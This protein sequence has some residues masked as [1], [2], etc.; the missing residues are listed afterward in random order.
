MDSKFGNVCCAGI[1]TEPEFEY[2]KGAGRVTFCNQSSY[3][4]AVKARFVQ[5]T[6]A[7]MDKKVKQP[8]I[9]MNGQNQI[10]C[11]S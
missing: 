9:I 1:D 6:Y 11:F 8:A 4:S 2:P 5:L 3:I 10:T 7:N